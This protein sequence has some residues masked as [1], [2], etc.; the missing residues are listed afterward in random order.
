MKLRVFL[1]AAE[2]R[3]YFLKGLNMKHC[4]KC[5]NE[6]TD[7][8]EGKDCPDCNVELEEGPN[9]RYTVGSRTVEKIDV[10]EEL[11][12]LTRVTQQWQADLLK[13]RL[14]I[15]GI[16]AHQFPSDM[17]T[18]FHLPPYEMTQIIAIIVS[19]SDYD[20]AL[21]IINSIDKDQSANLRVCAEC[22]HSVAPDD[23]TCQVCG[24]LLTDE[25]EGNDDQ[26]EE[27][28]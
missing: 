21:E 3:F 7:D 26:E 4:P 15:E 6:F 1:R 25:E 17:G 16:S 24:A 19:D 2:V 12:V 9:P 11:K 28:N 18:E 22:L 27:D 10:E 13:G 8:Y 23:E 5:I 14:E 20:K